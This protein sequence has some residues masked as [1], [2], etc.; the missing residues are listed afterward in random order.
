MK[1]SVVESFAV[2]TP[3]G[4]IVTLPTG[5]VLNLTE[6]QAEALG[7]KIRLA[8]AP[9]LPPKDRRQEFKAWVTE[10]GELRSRGVSDD[11]AGEIIAITSDDLPLQAKL[12]RKHIG[13]YSGA[14]WKSLVEDFEERAAIMQ[15]DGGLSREDA[16][17][18]AAVRLRCLA[19]L[20]ELRG[21]P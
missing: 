18:Q 7:G 13:R 8:D 4:N 9:A 15:Y 12:L 14:D 1:Y 11:L 17:H 20:D 2:K 10:S 6:E 5:R 16:E 19:F 3:Q 21:T